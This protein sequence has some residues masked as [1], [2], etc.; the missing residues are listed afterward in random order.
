M[1]QPHYDEIDTLDNMS[2]G[3]RNRDNSSTEM[4]VVKRNGTRQLVQWDKIQRRIKNLTVEHPVLHGVNVHRVAQRVFQGLVDGITTKQLDMLAWEE[5]AYINSHPDYE[6]LAMRLF[7]SNLHKESCDT[8]V[9]MIEL[10]HNHVHPLT[11]EPSPLISDDVYEVVRDNAELIQQQIDDKRDYATFSYFGI[12]TL[13][14][15]YLIRCGDKQE[16]PQHLF[17]RV[18]IGVWKRDL[19]NAFRMYHDMASR[20]YIHATPTLYNSGTPN[21]Q[22]ASCFLMVPPGDGDSIASIFDMVN[23]MALISKSAGGIGVGLSSIRCKGSY[24]RGTNGESNGLLPLLRVLDAT[25]LYVDQGGNKRPGSFAIYI[26][27]H[28]HDVFDVIE[29]KTNEG[30]IERKA[31]N[32]WPAMWI[33]DLFMRRVKNDEM[34]SLFDPNVARDLHLKWGAEYEELYHRYERDGLATRVVKAQDLWC[35]ILNCMIQKGAPFLC[36]KDAANRKSNQQYLGTIRLSNLCTEILEYTAPNEVAVCNLASL[37]LPT[38]VD[39]NGRFDHDAFGQAVRQLVRNLNRVIDVSQYVVPQAL[40]SNLKHRPIG[41]GVSGFADC[42]CMMGTCIT[43]SEARRINLEIFATMYYNAVYESNQLAIRHGMHIGC[44][45]SPIMRDGK[46]QFDLWGDS[47]IAIGDGRVVQMPDPRFDW[48]SLRAS[49]KQ[50]GMRNSLL[51]APMPTATT[52]QLM[53]NIESVEW[54]NTNLFARQTL[55]GDFVV[56]NRHLIK[57]LDERGLWNDEYKDQLL[58]SNGSVQSL[59]WVPDDIKEK[60]KTVWEISQRH[61]IDLAADRGH[62]ICQSQ[63]LN[64]YMKD[65]SVA[66]L[67]SMYFYAHERGIKTTYYLRSNAAA[68]APKLSI[69]ASKMKS[70]QVV[71]GGSTSET[72]NSKRGRFVCVGEE[73]CESCGI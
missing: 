73:G 67:T 35:A 33:S 42:L 71:T 17:M 7:V 70:E 58:A 24:I 12:R 46:F 55:A 20:K 48:E 44:E 29:S 56:I 26:E 5:A 66:K 2:A 16:R 6:R 37:S 3:K 36:F 64:L 62:Y 65:P 41:I 11:G 30:P 39:E 25:S 57:K 9:E 59:D 40:E 22:L 23:M 68:E 61:L 52:A 38:F 43:E 72:S 4:Y 21:N 27:P 13:A 28:H 54:F 69:E 15:K 10:M 60:F 51:I 49:I 34:W 50:H 14:R 31:H 19:E 53:D 8:F 45:R 63:S 1:Q 32:L 18:A 47:E